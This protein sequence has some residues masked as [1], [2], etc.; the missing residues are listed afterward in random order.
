MDQDRLH[1]DVCLGSEG[2]EE[3]REQA[4]ILRIIEQGESTV[5]EKPEGR[6]FLQYTQ[7]GF[8]SRKILAAIISGGGS[9]IK[10]TV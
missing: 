3:D 6:N 8:F 9:E 2:H 10:R 7:S 4:H 5:D 1:I